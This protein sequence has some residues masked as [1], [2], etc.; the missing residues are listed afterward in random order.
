M[1]SKKPPELADA[2][3]EFLNVDIVDREEFTSRVN[4]ALITWIVPRLYVQDLK[5]RNII[6]PKKA[7]DD[8]RGT[9]AGDA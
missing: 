9:R 5:D 4:N 8:A 3:A 2:I 1:A 7:S 6:S